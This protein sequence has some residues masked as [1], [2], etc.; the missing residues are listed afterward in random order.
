[1]MEVG[2]FC[3]TCP[4]MEPPLNFQVSTNVQY[5]SLQDLSNAI[6]AVKEVFFL[7]GGGHFTKMCSAKFAPVTMKASPK[8]ACHKIRWLQCANWNMVGLQSWHSGKHFQ[9]PTTHAISTLQP[10]LDIDYNF[11]LATQLYVNM[12]FSTI[13]GWRV[14][15]KVNWNLKHW[16]HWCEYH[17]VVFSWKIRIGPKLMTLGNRPKAGGLCL[18]SWMIIKCIM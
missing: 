9:I 3:D 16:I 2:H 12:D 1:M 15:A 4:H 18:W 6:L 5:W 11:S 14:I 13:I 10:Q 8:N 7:G 17:Y